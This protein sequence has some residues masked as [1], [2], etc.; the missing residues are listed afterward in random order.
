MNTKVG[1]TILLVEINTFKFGLFILL[2]QLVPSNV[3]FEMVVVLLATGRIEPQ[4]VGLILRKDHE[5]LTLPSNK[6][7]CP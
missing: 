3:F 4:S 1:T 2:L 7:M 5:I 6:V